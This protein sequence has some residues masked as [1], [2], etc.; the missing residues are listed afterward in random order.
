MSIKVS[1]ERTTQNWEWHKHNEEFHPDCISY[2]KC[3]TGTGI[4]C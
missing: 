3:A 4:M 2:Q 1:V